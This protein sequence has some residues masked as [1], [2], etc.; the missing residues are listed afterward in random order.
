MTSAYSVLMPLAPWEQPAIVAEALR[1][2][3]HQPLP[4][5]QVV[6]SCDGTPP[7]RLRA[8]LNEAPLNTEILCGPGGEGVGP[9]LARGLKACATELVIRADAD[10]ISL[11]ERCTRQVSFAL[12]NPQLAAISSAIA[13]FHSDPRQPDAIRQVPLSTE[14]I[15]RQCRWRNPLNHPAVLL[16]RSAVMTVGNYRHCPG[17]EDYD[18]WLRLLKAGYHLQNIADPL[19]L[20]RTGASHLARRRGWMYCRREAAFFWRCGQEGLL[21]W[22]SV[23]VNL[24]TR[25]PLRVLPAWLLQFVMVSWLRRA[26]Q[27]NLDVA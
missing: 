15:R 6:I 4:P 13:E 5:A 1:S 24:T 18:L 17:F 12:A 7:H 21:P 3:C 26:I 22:S 2:L 23:M 19:V 8:V 16:R 10:D 14:A 9:V 20:C 27:K 11:P 25:L